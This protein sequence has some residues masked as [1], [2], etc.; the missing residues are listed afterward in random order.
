MLAERPSL[1]RNAAL[2]FAA[3]LSSGLF[4]ALLVIFLTR[5]LGPEQFGLF[6]LA[7][8]IG[9]LLML[10]SDFGISAAA[11][12]FVAER[13]DDRSTVTDIT[14]Q[15]LRL[16]LS[17]TAAVSILLF[18]SASWIAAAFDE[19]ALAWPVRG[20]AIA[21]FGQSMFLFFGGLFLAQHRPDLNL[22]LTAVE[23][24]TELGASVA[25]VLLGAGAAGAAFGRG[26]G[27]LVGVLFGALLMARMLGRSAVEPR[28][29]EWT[30]PI[31]SYAGPLALTNSVTTT[32]AYLDTILVAA[33]LSST[34][35]ALVQA[36]LRL[37]PLV[38]YPA[39]AIAS[40][41]APALA[42]ESRSERSTRDARK[43]SA[44][45][46]DPRLQRFLVALRL[47]AVLHAAAV[48]VLLV[49]AGPIVDL[50]FGEAYAGSADILRALAPYVFL[51]GLAPLLS[52]GANYL[53]LAKG[54]LPIALAALAVNVVVDLALIPII[55]PIAAAVGLGLAFAVYVPGH[56]LL[57][58]RELG[59]SLRPL[60]LT[61][62]RASLAAGAASLALGAAGTSN[63][64]AGEW[65]AGSL[66]GLVLF[67]SVLV[68][69]R[70]LSLGDLR[71]A[72]G[73][74][75]RRVAGS[76]S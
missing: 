31:A 74:V 6:A 33:F 3:Q 73:V 45:R 26:M 63:L 27:Y 18:A 7:V 34:A 66:G 24:A 56:L 12:R 61:V 70:E 44:Q 36:P 17:A 53:G 64:S 54:R 58:R 16:K 21:V 25:L 72:Y 57:C 49:W 8:G 40:T 48:A 60:L 10:P 62:G 43:P 32:L 15:A 4:S 67:L 29:G 41:V 5:E 71:L 76:M 11:A 51:A 69:T 14:R 47:L 23:S 68:V 28:G 1:A 39:V 2:Q 22:R 75:R 50:L 9:A 55:G 37:V 30:R 13:A 59:F 46:D 19:S 65:I 35:V 20:V 38:L 52:F 42:R